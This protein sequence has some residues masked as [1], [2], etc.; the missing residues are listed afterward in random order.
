MTQ[1]RPI[2]R[3]TSSQLGPKSTRVWGV[4]PASG[5]YQFSGSGNFDKRVNVATFALLAD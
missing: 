5:V 1:T 3:Y 2:G 4:A